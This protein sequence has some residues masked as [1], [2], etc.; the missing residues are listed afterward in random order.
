MA[1][2]GGHAVAID[3]FGIQLRWFDRWLCGADNGIDAEP[4]DDL[5][6][7]IDQWRTETHLPLPD[8]Q[9]RPSS[10]SLGSRYLPGDLIRGGER[11][12][13]HDDVNRE[14]NTVSTGLVTVVK[15]ATRAAQ[16][17]AVSSRLL[18]K[19][20]RIAI[21]QRPTPSRWSPG[22]ARPSRVRPSR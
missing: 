15:K 1:G 16:V 12:S 7:G 11:D 17:I 6:Q 13:R 20:P 10:S 8:T 2:R 5:R 9:F 4:S 14:V 18:R 3:L 22:S 19:V 21:H